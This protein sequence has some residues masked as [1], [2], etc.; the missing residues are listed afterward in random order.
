MV[1]SLLYPARI[2]GLDKSIPQCYDKENFERKELSFMSNI[3]RNLFNTRIFNIRS[4]APLCL[5]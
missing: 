3:I 1:W 5:S 4:S 2:F